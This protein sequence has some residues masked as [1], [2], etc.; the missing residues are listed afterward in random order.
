MLNL[1]Q[2][3]LQQI[4]KM[5][6]IKNYKNMS[7]EGLLMTILKSERGLPEL[8]KSKCNNADI[9]ETK[10]SLNVSRDKFSR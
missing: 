9:E 2:I 7:K 4:A 6:H 1:S 3:E 10:R 5:R 8:Y